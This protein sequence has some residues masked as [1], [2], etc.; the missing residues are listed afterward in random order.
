MSDGEDYA[1]ENAL[2]DVQRLNDF[3]NMIT[4]GRVP[5]IEKYE[6]IPKFYRAVVQMPERKPHRGPCG[7][8]AHE[9]LQD[10]IPGWTE[11][12]VIAAGGR[13][14]GPDE[15]P[16]PRPPPAQRGGSKP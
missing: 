6:N 12:G 3:L 9:V 10:A 11:D 16:P 5:R 8:C 14:L 13:M 2:E 7:C 1:N 15:P 4:P